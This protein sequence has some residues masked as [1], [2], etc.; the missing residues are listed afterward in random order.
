MDGTRGQNEANFHGGKSW[1][2]FWIGTAVL[3]A[4]MTNRDMIVR[5]IFAA[6]LGRLKPPYLN[7]I[8]QMGGKSIHP[9]S[10]K[11]P[12]KSIVAIL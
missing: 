5:G 7:S 10:L 3:V 12:W 1:E 9:L 6:F 2:T 4:S 8:W 11:L